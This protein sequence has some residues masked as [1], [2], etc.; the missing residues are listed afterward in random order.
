MAS[1]ISS[2]VGVRRSPRL[3]GQERRDRLHDALRCRPPCRRSSGRTGAPTRV[4]TVGGLVTLVT[5]GSRAAARPHLLGAPQPDRD[6]RRLRH[7]PPDGRR[8][9]VPSARGRRTARPR[10]RALGHQRH[11][12]ARLQR[13]GRGAERLVGAA[14]PLDADAA[15]GPGERADDRRVEHLLLAEEAQRPARLHHR[16]P[17]RGGVEVAPVVGDDDRRALAA[18]SG[19]RRR[20]RTGRRGTARAGSAGARRRAAR[21]RPAWARPGARRASAS[22]SAAAVASTRSRGSG[23][24]AVGWPT[25]DSIGAS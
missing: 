5:L 6:D 14:P 23:F 7:A 15:H 3:G 4:R 10:D 25:A 22:A 24:T 19:R 13:L 17:H 16:Q 8:R 9:A 1:A 20:C 21:C 12:L 2:A 11:Q 18:G